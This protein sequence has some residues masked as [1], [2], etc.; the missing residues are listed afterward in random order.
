MQDGRTCKTRCINRP[1]STHLKAITDNKNAHHHTTGV[2][3]DVRSATELRRWIEETLISTTTGENVLY[4][5]L[6]KAKF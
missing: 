2:D 4:I 1:E 6:R 3:G 5:I